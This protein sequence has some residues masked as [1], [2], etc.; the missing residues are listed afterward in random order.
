MK[1]I[2]Y[3]PKPLFYFLVGS[4]IISILISPVIFICVIGLWF[5]YA[6][7]NWSNQINKDNNR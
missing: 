3:T 2:K 4:L 6:I 1:K 5:F 7:I